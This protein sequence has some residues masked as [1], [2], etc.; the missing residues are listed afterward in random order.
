MSY[1]KYETL[2]IQW[3]TDRMIIPR[4]TPQS[5]LNKCLSELSELFAAESQNNMPKIR[6]GVG[7]VVTCLINYCALRDIDLTECLA[8]AYADIKDRKGTLLEDGTF[9]KETQ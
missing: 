9:L 5:Q 7:D 8:L 6:D 3:A 1:A 2:I 4:A